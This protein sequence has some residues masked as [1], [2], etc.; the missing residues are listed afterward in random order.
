[1][2]QYNTIR[3]R[4]EHT[5]KSWWSLSFV[6]NSRHVVVDVVVVVGLWGSLLTLCQLDIMIFWVSSAFAFFKSVSASESCTCCC[7]CC[8]F[9]FDIGENWTI[10][11]N[12]L[13]LV[14]DCCCCC[15]GE[16]FVLVDVTFTF[17]YEWSSLHRTVKQFSCSMSLPSFLLHSKKVSSVCCCV[18][19]SA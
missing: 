15:G 5:T 12:V 9:R 6:L 4:W 10:C 16:R 8:C 18:T 14:L 2:K 11:I 3:L 19:V 7:C 13:F 1:M 17:C